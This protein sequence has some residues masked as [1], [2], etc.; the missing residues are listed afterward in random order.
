MFLN[1]RRKDKEKASF[2]LPPGG[3]DCSHN[4]TAISGFHTVNNL[5]VRRNLLDTFTENLLFTTAK[6]EICLSLF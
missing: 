1:G 3:R 5:R 4:E 2:L 6:L